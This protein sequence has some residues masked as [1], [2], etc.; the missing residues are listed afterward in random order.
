MTDILIA[1]V[2]LALGVW[3]GRRSMPQKPAPPTVE[4]QELLR[5][6]EDKQAFAR[7][8]EYNAE[9]AYGTGAWDA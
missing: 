5:L 2:L 7:L 4:E 3:L 1:V 8:M 6:Q 9:H